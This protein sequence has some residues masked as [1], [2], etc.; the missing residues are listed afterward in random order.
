MEGRKIGRMFLT[1]VFTLLSINSAD[2]PG[3]W[4]SSGCEVNKTDVNYTSCQCNRL[5]HFGVLMDLSRSVVDKVHEH[6][7][8]IVAYSGCGISSLFVGI[9]IVTHLVFHQLR[10]D[11]SSKILINL[12]VVLLMLNLSFLTCTWS[13]TF[14]NSGLCIAM[15]MLLHY[16]LLSSFTWMGLEAIHLYFL[17]VKVFNINVKNYVFKFCLIGWGVPATIVGIISIVKKDLY[18]ILKSSSSFCWIEDDLT[19][20]ISTVAYFCLIF[21]I[22]LAIFFT[23]LYQV[24]FMKSQKHRVLRSIV[25]HDLK[26]VASL[27]FLFGLTWSLAFFAWGPVR[28]YFFYFFSFLNV[29]QGFFVFVFHCLLKKNVRKHWQDCLCCRR[30]QRNNK[31]GGPRRSGLKCKGKH[32]QTQENCEDLLVIQS[33]EVTMPRNQPLSTFR[34]SQHRNDIFT[35]V[36]SDGCDKTASSPKYCGRRRHNSTSET[37]G[38]ESCLG[39]Y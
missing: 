31:S 8:M 17:V 3:G 24:S 25:L 2:G 28:T 5:T 27:I 13:A 1:L 9:T 35:K 33:Q 37:H 21:L 39:I 38:F 10:Q 34:G 14:D 29:A 23:V 30:L 12:C 15:A 36:Q 26:S 6:I 19:F 18:G 11:N 22:N 7:L 16:F 32:H 20:Y 4:N